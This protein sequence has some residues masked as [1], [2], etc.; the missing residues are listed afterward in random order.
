M[1]REPTE[2]TCGEC[3]TPFVAAHA[4][5]C[6]DCRWKHRGRRA[7]KYPWTPERDAYLR[8]HYDSRIRG[9]A[10]EIAAHFGGWPS[11][12]VK[13]RAQTLGLATPVTNRQDWSAA[14]TQFLLAHVGRRTTHWI[15]TQLRRSE[16]SV[17]LKCKRLKISRRY[18]M[19]YTLGDLAICFGTDEHVIA[20]WI[21]EGKLHAVRRGRVLHRSPWVVTDVDVL[22]FLQAHPMVFELRKVDQEWFMELLRGAGIFGQA[23]A[24]AE[25]RESAA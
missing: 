2:R 8:A 14:E 10:G 23:L 15:A 24:A 3:G 5:Y 1:K 20:R 25:Q 7:A 13:K 12:V 11:W 6:D 4:R 19:G 21:R 9:R 16:T 22:R 17:V 18:V